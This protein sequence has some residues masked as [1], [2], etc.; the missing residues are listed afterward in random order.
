MPRLKK[1]P[2]TAP[3]AAEP[4]AAGARADVRALGF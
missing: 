1:L 3:A 4:A 2:V